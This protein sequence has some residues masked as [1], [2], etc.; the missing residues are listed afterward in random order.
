MGVK[1]AIDVINQL[2]VSGRERSSVIMR[3]RTA[4]MYEYMFWDSA[5]RMEK[6]P[7]PLKS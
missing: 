3:F 6:F 4:A 2:E 5:Y 7:F 1:R